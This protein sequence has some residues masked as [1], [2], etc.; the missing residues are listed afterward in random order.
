MD[1]KKRSKKRKDCTQSTEISVECGVDRKSNKNRNRQ[2]SIEG[3]GRNFI[4]RRQSTSNRRR[5][6]NNIKQKSVEIVTKKIIHDPTVI[7]AIPC[8]PLFYQKIVEPV[9]DRH[10][11]N[12]CTV[13]CG[14]NINEIITK[15]TVLVIGPPES[16]KTSLINYLLREKEG[17]ETYYDPIKDRKN[18]FTHLGYSEKIALS[19]LNE[20]SAS[21]IWP[22]NEINKYS[23]ER[24]DYQIQMFQIKSPLLQEISFIDSPGI[25]DNIFKEGN[26]LEKYGFDPILRNLV[27][28]VDLIFFVATDTFLTTKST[29][30]ISFLSQHSKKTIFC[31]NK[32]DQFK[33]YESFA[34]SR[35]RFSEYVTLYSRY[36]E[37]KILCT[38]FKGVMVNE[39]VQKN[40][41][42]E[43]EALL[44]R[45]KNLPTSFK[46]QRISSL[47]THIYLVIYCAF[48]QNELKKREKRGVFKPLTEEEKAQINKIILGLP[49]GEKFLKNQ[50]E[51]IDRIVRY[52][53]ENKPIAYKADDIEALRSFSSKD[54]PYIQNIASSE[55][56]CLVK[57]LLPLADP[58][59]EPE[60]P[61]KEKKKI[62]KEI[63]IAFP[64]P[65]DEEE[66][67]DDN[68]QMSK[69][70]DPQTTDM[71]EGKKDSSKKETSKK[72]DGRGGKDNSEKRKEKFIKID[73]DL[74]DSMMNGE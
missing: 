27:M 40:V 19:R 14:W 12:A 62:I 17:Y 66:E 36:G 70:I 65:D 38:Y 30:I 3:S 32:C 16:G 53:G 39:Q 29:D 57:F 46:H 18:C 52:C 68:K 54:F 55:P 41:H 45:I 28:K 72:I 7:G 21:K 43:N 48:I 15:P 34:S 67:D 51:Y 13:T 2:K 42:T 35:K 60:L 25:I 22:Y 59:K 26:N 4:R 11:F 64:Q 47:G 20:I 23:R 63:K 49:N 61:V 5:N 58:N 31:L 44:R 56:E 74:I 6:N 71:V 1:G 37:P 9:R 33:N 24:N 69:N 73:K 8:L 50:I 10:N